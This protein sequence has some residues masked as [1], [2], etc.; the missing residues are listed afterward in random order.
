MTARAERETARIGRASSINRFRCRTVASFERCWMP[1][2]MS[3][4]YFAAR[5]VAQALTGGLRKRRTFTPAR[6]CGA[7]AIACP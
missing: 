4:R 1:G 5:S 6:S 2:V 3:T 7:S